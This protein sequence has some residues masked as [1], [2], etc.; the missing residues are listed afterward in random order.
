MIDKP[1][2]HMKD[3]SAKLESYLDMIESVFDTDQLLDSDVDAFSTADYYGKSYWAYH[4]IH[5]TQG[6][7][8][9]SMNFDGEFD[10][11]GYYEQAKIVEKYISDQNSSNILE[12]ASGTGFNSVLLAKKHECKHFEGIDLTPKHVDVSKNKASG[13]TNLEFHK[14]DF[15]DLQYEPSSF[16]IV[17]IVESLGHAQDLT[18]ALTEAYRVL[19][20]GGYFIVIDGFRNMT[21]SELSS[22]WAKATQLVEK[23]MSIPKFAMLGEFVERSRDVG[24]DVEAINDYSTPIMPTLRRYEDISKIYYNSWLIKT[25]LNSILPKKLLMNSVAGLLMPMTVGAEIHRYHQA[26][27]KK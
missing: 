24:F 3:R 5:S 22:N 2:T 17:F 26:A 25:V 4:F 20:Q 19:T 6:S 11:S 1:N 8:H 12:L 13:I 14:G 18:K 27:L 16:D 15:H 21:L 23:T 10:K 7:I 9:M